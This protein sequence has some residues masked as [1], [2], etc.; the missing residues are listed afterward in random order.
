MAREFVEERTAAGEAADLQAFLERV[1][2]VAD[3][4]QI[5]DAAD[6]GGVVTLMTCTPRRAWSSRSCS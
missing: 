4:D 1:A 5:P 2:L 6:D 3:A